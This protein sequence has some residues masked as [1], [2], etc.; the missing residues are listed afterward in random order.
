[1]GIYL[2]EVSFSVNLNRCREV[3]NCLQCD[4]GYLPC[5]AYLKRISIFRSKKAALFRNEAPVKYH[6]TLVFFPLD[7]LFILATSAADILRDRSCH[8]V[9]NAD[10]DLWHCLFMTFSLAWKLIHRSTWQMMTSVSLISWTLQ[11]WKEVETLKECLWFLLRKP[12]FWLVPLA[13][14]AVANCIYHPSS[15][16]AFLD[17]LINC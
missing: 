13:Y 1:V 6:N 10:Y 5:L 2:F 12:S 15:S 11:Q 4:R 16:L 7:W 8:A 17:R 14:V 3:L 9:C